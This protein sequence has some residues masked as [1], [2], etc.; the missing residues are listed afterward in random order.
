MT[1]DLHHR[2]EGPAGAPVVAFG[3]SLGTA[4]A[5]WDDQAAA[6][7]GRFRVLR[8][9]HR[10]HGGSPVPAGPYTVEEMAEDVVALLD[11]L[12]IERLAYCGLSLGGMVGMRL[13]LAHPERIERLV[14]C[15][16]SAHLGP[17]EMWTERAA[18]AR[19]QG[20]GPLVAASLER[21]FT[22]DAPPA[23]V[24]KLEAMLRAT[25]AEGY[26]GGCEALAGND[27]RGRLGAIRAPTLAVAGA[28]D[29][30]APPF[31]LEAIRDQ[32]PGARLHVIERARHIANVERADEFN[33]ILLRFLDECQQ[34]AGMRVRREVL[35]DAHVDAAIA[36]TT[37][38]TADFQ[39]LITRYAWGEI[40]TRPG[41]D[42]RTRSAIALTALVARGH[43]HEL[44]MHVR[45]A[46]RNGLTA[47]E[48][49]EVLLQTAIY[50]GV[51]A[52]NAAFATAQRV[53]DEENK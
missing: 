30:A 31:H 29:P 33:R 1:V 27:L 8:F 43:D 36:R 44:A 13:A 12:G 38:F 17:P 20:V 42:R 15:C 7:S 34:S 40:W 5:M 35:G 41:L 49:K 37:D 48:I 26:A 25:D 32:I 9:D 50:C 24:A 18:T 51:A 16:T 10:G 23:M 22:P 39:D 6:L 47:A 11:R 45:A 14:V 46:L 4:L 2:L 28:E 21:W 53:I 19:E 3:T 52:A